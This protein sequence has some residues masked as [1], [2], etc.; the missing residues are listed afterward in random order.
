MLALTIRRALRAAWLMGAL[1]GGAT[2]AAAATVQTFSPQGEVARVRQARAT[3][4]ESM[5]RFGDPRL[6]APF[7]VRCVNPTPITGTGRWVDDKTWVYD[8]T[9]DVPAGVRCDIKLKAGIR[10]I[11]G[12]PITDPTSFEFSTG[13]PA[14][15][16]TYPEAG[17]YSTIE[18][19]QVFVFLLNGAATP[20]SIERN[21]YCE[22]SGI[23]ERIGLQVVTGPVRDA[24]LKAVGLVPQ[25]ARAVALKC[26]RPLPNESQ[27]TVVWGAGIATP[28]GVP[29]SAARRVQYTV[30]KPFAA[31]FTCERTSSRADCLPIRPMRV[32]FSSPVPRKFAE[33]IVLVAPDGNRK[34]LLEQGRGETNEQLLSVGDGPLRKFIYLFSRSKGELK[35]DP[36]ESGVNAVQ[37]SAP[38]PENAALRVDMP[39]DLRDDAGR[40]LSNADAFPLQTRTAAAPAL[41]KFPAA[42]FGVLELNAEPTLPVTVRHVEADL[43]LKGLAV[44][45]GAVKDL[46]LTDDDQIIEWLAKVKRYDETTLRREAVESELGIKLPVPPKPPKSARKSRRYGEEENNEDDDA[47]DLVQSRT[48]SLLARESVARRL[49]LPPVA[50]N[51]PRPFEVLGIPMPQAGFHVVEVE[52]PKLGASLLD[53]NAPMYVRTSVLVTNLGVHFKWGAV[54]SAIWACTSSGA[55][56]LAAWWCGRVA[57]TSKATHSSKRNCRT[58][59]GTIATAEA[60]KTAAVKKATSSAH[61]RPMPPAA[62]TWPSSGRP[63]TRASSRG[64]SM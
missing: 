50:T 16:R 25:Q 35:A 40:V 13:G 22:A 56:T 31:S 52:S 11:A 3:F 42:T 26:A 46:R 62:P 34:P 43:Q 32:E 44:A 6:P 39:K 10:S 12:Q 48:L 53:R 20:A 51:D 64:D 47:R 28:S 41:V 29:T 49:T 38:L 18:E 8:F 14:I 30:R 1:L 24:I 37:F 57:A 60:A 58:H 61:E 45:P 63:G 59:A 54:N 5:V 9:N 19:E 2:W 23:G 17:E 7:E 27:A 21:G 36:S 4:S 33:R 55:P 15:V